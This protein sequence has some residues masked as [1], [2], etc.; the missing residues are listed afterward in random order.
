MVSPESGANQDK[1]KELYVLPSQSVEIN[2]GGIFDP[3]KYYTL[4]YNGAYKIE[5]DDVCH[6]KDFNHTMMELVLTY[7]VCLR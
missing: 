6:I 7:M 2:S 1:Y 3:I 4:D 5:A